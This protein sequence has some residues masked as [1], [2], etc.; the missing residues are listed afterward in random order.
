MLQMLHPF[1]MH[2]YIGATNKKKQKKRKKQNRIK[3]E[4]ISKIQILV[5]RVH[6]S[7]PIG[8]TSKFL[9]CNG[10]ANTWSVMANVVSF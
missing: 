5:L 2:Q 3:T 7:L 6:I 9:Q 1:I 10:A 4:R 8:A